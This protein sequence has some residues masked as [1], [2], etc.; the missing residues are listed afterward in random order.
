M[1][2]QPR[3]HGPILSDASVL[4]GSASCGSA[5]PD[6]SKRMQDPEISDS[7]VALGVWMWL[8]EVELQY[9]STIYVNYR[10]QLP[11]CMLTYFTFRCKIRLHGHGTQCRLPL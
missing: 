7:M 5:H 4:V 6:S 10:G 9:L 8:C 1:A 3:Y 2:T 11:G